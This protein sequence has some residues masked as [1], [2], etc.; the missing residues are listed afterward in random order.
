MDDHNKS[1]INKELDTDSYFFKAMIRCSEL[2][3]HFYHCVLHT[4]YIEK[5]IYGKQPSYL[6]GLYGSN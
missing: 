2:H 4:R 5:I 3:M 1:Y 6:T